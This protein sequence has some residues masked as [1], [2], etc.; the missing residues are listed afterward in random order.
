MSGCFL[1]VQCIYL[2][3]G[4]AARAGRFYHFPAQISRGGDKETQFLRDGGPDYANLGI[5][6]NR[7]CRVCSRF[8]I[9]CFLSILN[10][11]KIQIWAEFRNFS[12]SPS[13]LNYVRSRRKVW[14][15][16]KEVQSSELQVDVL[17]FR[18]M[19]CSFSKPEL[20]NGFENR[21][22]IS[23]FRPSPCKIMGMVSSMSEWILRVWPQSD[24]HI[25]FGSL[26]S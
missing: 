5:T 10:R 16:Q 12:P 11:L 4:A 13:L 26:E 22:Q 1:F 19:S 20:V 23:H 21:G 25:S 2:W 6:C 24:M 18:C 8:Q 9:H 7:H 17:D 3:R 14:V 15:N